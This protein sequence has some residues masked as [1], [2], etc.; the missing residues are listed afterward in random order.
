MTPII[1]LM[2]LIMLSM[3]PNVLLGQYPLLTIRDIQEPSNLGIS[4][5]SPFLGDTVRVRG[6]VATGPRDIW[7]GARWSFFLVNTAGGPWSGLQIVQHDSFSSGTDVGLLQTGDS[8]IVT[9]MIEE[10]QNATQLAILT[11]PVVSVELLGQVTLGTFP[12]RPAEISMEL[13]QN[14]LTGE[15]FEK[16]LIKLSDVKMIINNVGNGEALIESSDGAFQI[17]L[18]DWNNDLHTC[19][20]SGSCSWP[21]NGTP[22]D[23]VGYIRD[24]TANTPGA[25]YMIA[26][27]SLGPPYIVTLAIP[28]VI[29]DIVRDPAA[30]SSS[31]AVTVSALIIDSDGTVVSASLNYAVDDGAYQE[32]SMNSAVNIFS[33]DIPAQVEGS[34]VKYFIKAVD[35]SADFTISPGDTANNPLFYF[36]RD[37]ALLIQDIQN[38][39]FGSGNSG[40]EDMEVTTR[41]IVT[42]D[43]IQFGNYWIQNGNG[44]WSGLQINDFVNN[45]SPGDEVQVTGTVNESFGFTRLD[46]ISAYTLLGS[47]NP[48]PEPRVFKTGDINTSADSAEA[49]ESV[50]VE[51]RNVLVSNELPDFPSNF[52]EF[53]VDDGSGEIRVDDL[54]PVFD[55]NLNLE[56]LNGDGL[57]LVRGYLY[58]SFGNFKIVPRDT[59]DVGNFI[60]V[61]QARNLDIAAGEDLQHIVTHIPLITFDYF[62]NDGMPQTA[63]QIQISTLLDFSTIDMWN[64]D[65]VI[66]SDTSIPYSG[67]SLIDGTTYYL[68]TKVG[69]GDLWSGWSNLQ[70]RMNSIPSIPITIGPKNMETIASRLP[71]FL[72]R[73][74]ID[75]EL[76]L[77]NYEFEIETHGADLFRTWSVTIPESRDSDSTFFV[78]PE[79]IPNHQAYFWKVRAYDNFE[80]SDFSDRDSFYVEAINDP[81]AHFETISPKN[82]TL[83]T[84]LPTFV[85]HST[86]DPNIDD[87][88][89]YLLRISRDSN[90]DVPLLSEL[91][92]DTFYTVNVPLADD[93]IFYWAAS[94]VD[95]FSLTGFSDTSHFLL[96][97]QESPESFSLI[98]PENNSQLDLLRPI[99][100]WESSVDPDPRDE[101]K[102][103]LIILSASDTIYLFSGIEDTTHHVIEDIEIG[104]YK[105]H[106]IAEDADD[107]SLDTPS[108]EVFSLN[109]IVGIDDEFTGIPEEYDLYQ[110]YPNPFNPSTVIKYA[111]P[112][113]SGVSL[114]IY[115]I[116]GQEVMRWDE[117]NVT[118][119]YHEKRWDGKTQS[120]IPVSS[121]IYVYRLQAGDFVQ[122][123]KMLLLK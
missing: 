99:F 63:Y 109:I 38:N 88:I 34:L 122:T 86:N 84:L 107:S 103:T 111:L 53:S 24:K 104:S 25:R 15:Q 31:D 77:L 44:P 65:T 73:N 26:P 82:D 57:E 28:P 45:P 5:V 115:N 64:S 94:A 62:D 19:L 119:G 54:S 95:N 108:S 51:V 59:N 58:W 29:S 13:L 74:S 112:E 68:R 6:V 101:V 60:R 97:F 32:V 105:W 48:V 69:S 100:S 36:I 17:S 56:Y 12:Q 52:G 102:Y 3:L 46:A 40:Y 96:D 22:M 11:N 42:S 2:F 43:P 66:S 113:A 37:G 83:N 80:Y 114:V 90:L 35:D 76:D 87:T 33:A 16:T 14:V 21:V 61:L 117:S 47:G 71:I 20:G 123:R 41:G 93:S 67:D 106:L 121:G 91:I 18:E 49:Y 10:I 92:S 4:D 72:I 98:S 89:H 75:A 78:F 85:W 23:I 118:P 39:P 55:G 81:P 116:M 9:G 70:F 110:N 30:P 79:L 50:L 7:I 1:N 120:G 8:I 27:W